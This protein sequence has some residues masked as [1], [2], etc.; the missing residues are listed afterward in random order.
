MHTFL[1]TVHVLIC[2]V[3]T[4]LTVVYITMHYVQ[5]ISARHSEIL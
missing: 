5:G 4:L 3:S 2:T 1:L